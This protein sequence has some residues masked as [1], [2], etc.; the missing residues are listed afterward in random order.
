MAAALQLVNLD[1]RGVSTRQRQ[2][3]VRDLVRESG[4]DK[5]AAVHEILA[6]RG[7]VNRN[8]GQPFSLSTV[9]NDLKGAASQPVR[10]IVGRTT[11]INPMWKWRATTSI[12][13]TQTDYQFWDKLRRGKAAGFKLSG[14]LCA[15][16]TQIIAS[17]AAGNGFQVSLSD[18][19]E[20]SA[21][22]IEYTNDLL[23]RF[24]TRYHRMLLNMTIDLFALGDQYVAVNPDGTVSRV[25]PELTEIT[26]NPLDYR[27]YDSIEVKTNLEEYT[28]TDTFRRDGRTIN[29]NASGSKKEQVGSY[30]YENLIGCLPLVHFANDRG[31][32]ELYGRPIYEPMLR[33]LSRYD[34]LLEKAL[35]GG[36]LMGNPIPTFQG[37]KNITETIDANSTVED[38]DYT[39]VDGNEE[40]RT[41][42]NFDRLPA[43]FVGEGGEFRFTAPPNGFTGDTRALLKMLFLLLLDFTRVPEAVWGGAINSSK[44]SAEA[45]MPPFHQYLHARRVALEGDGADVEIGQEAKGGLYE[46]FDI[47]LRTKAL[48]DPRIVVAP[49][50]I[51]WPELGEANWEVLLK[52][53]SYLRDTGAISSETALEL[54]GKVDNPSATLDEAREELDEAWQYEQKH[55]A[56]SFNGKLDAAEQDAAQHAQ[57]EDESKQEGPP[58]PDDPEHGAAKQQEAVEG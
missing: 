47:L 36:E 2:R 20:A 58:L 15:P 29:I 43:I 32:N 56:E 25:A 37:M 41:L 33:L 9:R 16:L 3:I 21:A 51:T 27:D 57:E 4:V 54:F 38:E 48:T 22:N 11:A 12:D 24:S 13:K 52:W 17:F 34:D 50:V 28:I 26:S 53:V 14:L 23:A 46:L 5:P 6:E 40:T 39:D 8:T 19:T 1:E 55:R 45:Q 7:V 30:E 49:T 35:D 44:A 31:T 42:I 10:E 18:Q